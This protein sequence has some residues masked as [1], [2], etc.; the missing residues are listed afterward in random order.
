MHIEKGAKG[1]M[2]VAD[3]GVPA[4]EFVCEYAGELLTTIEAE[5]RLAE[6]DRRPADRQGHALLVVREIMPS[7]GAA[8]RLNIDATARG[9]VARFMNHSCDG[10]NTE[11]ALVRAGAPCCL[12]RASLHPGTSSPGRSSPSATASQRSAPVK[13]TRQGARASA[14]AGPPLAGGSFR[15]PPDRSTPMIAFDCQRQRPLSG[16]TFFGR[17]RSV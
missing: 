1:W 9:N 13:A 14:S 5:L 3:A 8:L 10:G 2:L 12:G 6:Y 4:G 17:V 7:G 16:C 11:L 15:H